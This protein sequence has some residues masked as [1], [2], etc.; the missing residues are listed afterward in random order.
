MDRKHFMII[1]DKGVLWSDDSYDAFETGS[2]IMAAV[3]NGNKK[4]LVKENL[5]DSW[6]GDLVLVQ[7]VFRTR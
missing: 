1:D 7:E 3:E 4:K 5:G 2:E 6:T